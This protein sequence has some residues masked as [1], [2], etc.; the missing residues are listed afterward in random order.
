MIHQIKSIKGFGIFQNYIQSNQLNNFNRYNLFYGW[1]GSGKSTLS[2]LFECIERRE[3]CSGHTEAEWEII[4]DNGS[5]T[6]KNIKSATNNIHVFNR[7]FIERNVFTP[8]DKINGINIVYISEIQKEDKI[9]LDDKQENLEKKKT[10]YDELDEK[11]YG[12]TN[13]KSNGL[14][15]EIDRFLSDAARTIKSKFQLIEVDDK[16]LINY[17]KTKLLDFINENVKAVNTKSNTLTV[18]EI[19]TLRKSIKPQNKDYIN[20][21]QVKENNIDILPKIYERTV[22]LQLSVITNKV[23]NHLKDNPDI[24]KW[25]YEGIQSNI[26]PVGAEKCEFCGNK[27]SPH[28]INELNDHF[29]NQFLELKESLSKGIEWI[30]ENYIINDFPHISLLYDELQNKYKEAVNKC[31]NVASSINTIMSEWV[32]ILQEKLENP[33]IIPEKTISEVCQDLITN[34]YLHLKKIIDIIQEHNTKYNSLEEIVKENKKKIE[35]H[36]VSE[37]TAK[38]NYFQ[39]ESQEAEGL[40]TLKKIEDEIKVLE[41]EIKTLKNKLSNEQIGADEFNK[42]LSKFLGRNDLILEH[43]EEGG[44]II[45]SS[46]IY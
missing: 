29:S 46:C 23:I 40:K 21:D 1:N 16:R 22:D 31:E 35:L 2:N 44:Y 36:Y 7:S 11:L 39:R 30:E 26:H 10:L 33:F 17:N 12:N 5:L 37:E 13:S 4:T 38:Y 3:N 42:K 15:A 19:E 8:D 18:A 6:E 45:K 9:S 41:K 27:L 24:S 20:L 14:I 34:Y 43:K 25:V 28:R 32:L